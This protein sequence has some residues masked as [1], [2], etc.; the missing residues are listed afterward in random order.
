MG[1]GSDHNV[2]YAPVSSEPASTEPI[3]TSP[4]AAP[5]A[6]ELERGLLPS[7]PTAVPQGYFESARDAV[8]SALIAVRAKFQERASSPPQKEGYEAPPCRMRK[9]MAC[10][11]VKML[12]AAVM[13]AL[14]VIAA[15]HIFHGPP[16]PRPW[17]PWGMETEA[18]A[19][20]GVLGWVKGLFFGQQS[21]LVTNLA[22]LLIWKDDLIWDDDLIPGSS[23]N[24]W[25]VDI[26]GQHKEQ[27]L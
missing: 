6:D 1:K 26:V 15:A 11:G 9:L 18:A 2:H 17:G 20:T 12:L 8:N 7:S 10:Q 27:T 25:E 16:P 23:T 21:G 4:M 24:I 3:P 19:P 14:L 22:I 13:G 5:N